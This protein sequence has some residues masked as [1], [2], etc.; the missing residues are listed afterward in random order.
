[1]KTYPTPDL[2]ATRIKGN[3][4]CQMVPQPFG[5]NAVVTLKKSNKITHI[6][7]GGLFWIPDVF[8]FSG[9]FGV[10]EVIPIE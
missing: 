10:S 7:E 8:L 3:I 4:C 5:A 1:M 2:P 9:L 6:P